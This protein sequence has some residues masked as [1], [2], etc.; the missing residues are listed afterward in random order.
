MGKCFHHVCAWLVRILLRGTYADLKGQI[1]SHNSGQ[2]HSISILTW[3]E[4]STY[5][6]RAFVRWFSR[7]IHAVFIS[8]IL[9]VHITY[10][11][12]LSNARTSILLLPPTQKVTH[13]TEY[14]T[15]IQGTSG[16]HSSPPINPWRP[17]KCRRRPLWNA[18]SHSIPPP[19]PTVWVSAPCYRIWCSLDQFAI[20]KWYPRPS[21]EGP[22]PSEVMD[23]PMVSILEM[24]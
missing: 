14:H 3:K 12:P 23:S 7:L 1:S 8:T 19:S 13:F 15:R 20:Q 4:P 22:L 5:S 21:S 17:L 16:V 6:R 9:T 10:E 2:C 24:T 11:L 18:G